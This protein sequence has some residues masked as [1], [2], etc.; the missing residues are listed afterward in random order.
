MHKPVAIFSLCLLGS[1]TCSPR[2]ELDLSD[3]EVPTSAALTAGA[4]VLFVVGN[5][6]LS[7]A[8]AAVRS[9]LQA[10]GA[11]VIVMSATAAQSGD[12]SGKALVVIS[13][14]VASGNVNT[15][16]RDTPVAVMC[17]ENALYDDM[18]M[19]GAT[20]GTNFGATGGQTQ[21]TLVAVSHPLAAGLDIPT[22]SSAQTYAWGV[23]GSAADRIATLDGNPTR[24]VVFA[25]RQGQ[26]MV[27][28][29]APGRRLGFFPAASAPTALTT[30]GWKLFD[31]AVDWL[32]VACTS[33]S[34]CPSPPQGT[35][36]CGNGVCS[37]Q[38]NVGFHLCGSSCVA[39]NSP[40]SCGSSCTA[41]PP[42]QNGTA[43]CNAGTCGFVC[44]PG[45]HLCGSSCV[46]ISPSS[47]GPSCVVCPPVQ[48]GAPTCN[49]GTC[50]VACNTGFHNCS[51]TCF[52]N[53]SSCP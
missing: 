28:G 25:Y 21:L 44:N 3:V 38:C 35:G 41:C 16:F 42:A 48:H 31:N 32:T 2:D 5:T 23:P 51:G 53:S 39:N 1:S 29:T 8:D 52:P 10:L 49:G 9:R 36:V 43:T 46:P 15:K 12:A 27:A 14:S 13:D 37:V 33:N 34:E 20:S 7:A 45:F 19:T 26:P 4:Q 17:M 11:T 30:Q 6:T 24:A 47:C 40:G 18:G 22:T 50:G